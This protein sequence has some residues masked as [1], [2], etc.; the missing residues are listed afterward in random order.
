MKMYRPA[1]LDS[2]KGYDKNQLIKD[3]IA[4]VIVAIIAFPLSVALAI[5]SGMRPEQGLYTAIIGGVFVS[6]FGGSR[7]Q[8]GGATAATVM[9]VFSII[10]EYGFTGLAVASILAGLILIV[11]GLCKVG[12]LLPYIPYSITLAFTAAIGVGIFTGQ[13]KEF[14]GMKID[15]LP[16]KNLS[17][18]V[19]Y[20][21]HIGTINWQALLIGVIALAV[22]IVWPKINSV[23]PNSLVAILVTTP[24]VLLFKMDVNTIQ[25]VYGKLPSH[26]PK[27][28]V[29]E[30]SLE[31]IEAVLPSA[32]TLAILVAIVSLL[33]CVVTDGLTGIRHDSNSELIG[34]GIANIFCG[35]FGA[36]PVAGAVAR[37]SVSV[38]NGGKTP[39]VGVVHSIVVLIILLVMMPLAGF[40]PMP[41]L[42]AILILVAYNMSNVPAIISLIFKAP[43]T[44]AVIFL[45]T[46]TAGIFVD[47]M[48][49]IEVGVILTACLFMRRMAE[50]TSVSGWKYVEDADTIGDLT[51]KDIVHDL[52]KVPVH[53]L[54]YE[55]SG[56]M[57]FAASDELLN[58]KAK[59]D[60]RVLIIRMRSV[61]ALDITALNTLRKIHKECVEKDIFLIFSHVLGQPYKTMQKNGF[62][63]E[64]GEE[65]FVAKISDALMLADD[66]VKEKETWQF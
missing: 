19:T 3:M 2:L 26:F 17:R 23:I 31:L 4:G 7:V 10:G 38:K 18:I 52:A 47:L 64:I 6:L 37:S 34:Q 14:F 39:I 42:A 57:F 25:S 11:M 54:V 62:V 51:D 32:V 53:T 41:T 45:A 44:D 63:T 27:P 29:P 40:I 33:S 50:V 56:P 35:L 65:H 55:I 28:E 12:A 9:T 49:A 1:L 21:E 66:I 13:L 24:I 58:I 20:A 16:V 59:A 48:T 61:P 43:K 30:F 22:L 8:I 46:F 60:T 15:S 5:S 36:V